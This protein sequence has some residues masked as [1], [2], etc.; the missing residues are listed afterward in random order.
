MAVEVAAVAAPT[1]TGL[2]QAVA[3]AAAAAAGA[4]KAG[5]PRAGAGAAVRTRWRLTPPAGAPAAAQRCRR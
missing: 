3:A 2:L 5:P 4:A 1:A